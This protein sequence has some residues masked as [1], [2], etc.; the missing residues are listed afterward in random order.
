MSVLI[1]SFCSHLTYIETLWNEAWN[2]PMEMFCPDTPCFCDHIWSHVELKVMLVHSKVSLVMQ[3]HFIKQLIQNTQTTRKHSSRMCT[4]H[5]LTIRAGGVS[6]GCVS[7]VCVCVC[8]CVCEQRGCVHGG[9]C[10]SR[11]YVHTPGPRGTTPV[12]K[13]SDRQ[14]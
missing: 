3:H 2:D 5:L 14:V 9:E 13:M 12:N 10:V 11:G 6:R 1:T 4:A 7:K 8:A